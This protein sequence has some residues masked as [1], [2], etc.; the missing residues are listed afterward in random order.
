MLFHIKIKL[1]TKFGYL[2]TR[3]SD[4]TTHTAF[5]IMNFVWKQFTNRVTSNTSNDPAPDT[6]SDAKYCNNRIMREI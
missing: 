3:A 2:H 1:S 4:A 5:G 6:K